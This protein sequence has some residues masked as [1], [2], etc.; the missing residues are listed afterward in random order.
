[1]SE[2]LFRCPLCGF[3]FDAEANAACLQCPLT[4]NCPMICCPACGH[5]TLDPGR[6]I[7]GRLAQE[8]F[9][10]VRSTAEDAHG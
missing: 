2:E 1:M 8:A 10:R 5:V 6:S 9:A 4:R 3:A 7:L